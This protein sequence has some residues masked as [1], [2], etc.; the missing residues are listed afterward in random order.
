[1]PSTSPAASAAAPSPWHYKPWWCQPWSIV[2]TGTGLIALSWLGLGRWWVT[3]AV[4]VPLCLW[5]G[6]F[7]LLWPRLMVASG[8]LE[9]LPVE[10]PSAL[11]SAA[12]EPDRQ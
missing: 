5:M 8:L 9:T 6:Y 4:A 12:S 11:D 7:V 3:L 1:M 2:L 10:P